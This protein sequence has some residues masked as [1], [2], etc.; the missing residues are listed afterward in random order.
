MTSFKKSIGMC[1]FTVAR[2]CCRLARRKS[3]GRAR[4]H[5][6]GAAPCR[7]MWRGLA[8]VLASLPASDSFGADG[9]TIPGRCGA[10]YEI[11]DSVR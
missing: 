9:R 11:R 4:R 6:V 3:V 10:C 2:V 8:D 5:A 1:T 7:L